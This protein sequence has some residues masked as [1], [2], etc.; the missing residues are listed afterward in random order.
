MLCDAP[1]II[2]CHVLITC[3]GVDL[4]VKNPR[5]LALRQ[6][7]EVLLLHKHTQI[8]ELP[9]R[10]WE[11]AIVRDKLIF[12]RLSAIFH[13]WR[14]TEFART[15]LAKSSSLALLHRVLLGHHVLRVLI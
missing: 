3:L 6:Q 13:H 7:A 12:R 5:D 11:I 8:V 9:E 14:L 15:H 1:F 10:E 4:T 2:S